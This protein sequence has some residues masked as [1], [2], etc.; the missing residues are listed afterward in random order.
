MTP[1][2][3]SLLQPSARRI[4]TRIVSQGTKAPSA[5]KSCSF[6]SRNRS[7]TTHSPLRSSLGAPA[8]EPQ[9]NSRLRNALSFFAVAIL[10]SGAGFTIA[11]IPALQA[12]SA[13]LKR[14]TDAET[15]LMFSPED[16]TAREVERFLQG[17]PLTA[18]MRSNPE[19]IEARPHLKTP[20]SHQK[21]SLTIGS[22]IGPGKIVVPPI[23]WIERG[24]KSLVSISYLGPDLCG[25]PGIVH[26]G[27]LAT[28]MDEGLAWCCF[29]ALP[30][31]IGLTA[32]LN[33]N[34][35][36]PAPAETYVVLRAKTT[37]VEGRKAWVEGRIE[38]LPK[39]GEQPVVLV[40]ATA[41]FIEPKQ[42]ANMA[43]I[44]PV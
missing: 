9:Q 19:L 12:A 22:L 35:R 18:E 29:G 27:L 13:F 17:H 7:F 8:V 15:L 33:I 5:L 37:K 41:L 31:K 40:E 24:G 11:A 42:A 32:N 20:P 6:P 38:T 39:D 21:H 44:Y 4:S 43:R 26:G 36:N 14:P 1:L 28:L 34:Y 30:N 25:H 10:F 2:A 16:E 3:R 23:S